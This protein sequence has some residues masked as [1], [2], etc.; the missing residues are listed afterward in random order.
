[1]S[2]L[3]QLGNVARRAMSTGP[4]TGTLQSASMV[5][6]QRAFT[7]TKNQRMK[8]MHES[9][10]GDDVTMKVAWGLVAFGGANI[11]YN[12]IGLISK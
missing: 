1:M 7:S 10:P 4:Q 6:E 11:A 9:T 3:R 2:S 5:A 8:W 12:L